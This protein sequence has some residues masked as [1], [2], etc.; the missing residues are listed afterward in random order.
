[1]LPFFLVLVALVSFGAGCETQKI[2]VP[3]DE[4]K[5]TVKTEK[6]LPTIENKEKQ[7]IND[8]TFLV[9][10]VIDGDTIEIEGG[11]K[12]RYIGIDT[13]ETVDP[14]K[15]VQCFGKE[16]SNRNKQLVEG[17]RVHLEK[18]ITETDRYGRLLRY[19]YLENIFINLLLV[20]EGFATSYSY[21]PDI[22]YQ[23]KFIEAG[24]IAR[25]KKNGLWG[26]CPVVPPAPASAETTVPQPV[27]TPMPT[28]SPQPTTAPTSASCN[29]KGN[30]SSGGKIYH[31]PGCSSYNQ[32]VINE[33]QG[34][35]WF[36]TEEEAVAVGWRKAKNCP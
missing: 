28:T 4:I 7:N 13:P 16:A 5:E 35:R 19:V 27:P 23:D 36:C 8:G 3:K 30:I 17:K 21:P 25:D 20:Q 15:P 32:T 11:Q 6:T 18:D 9:T 29:I 22:K 24:R 14:R 12:I 2:T 33:V 31:L 26:A 34:E 1:M 10:R